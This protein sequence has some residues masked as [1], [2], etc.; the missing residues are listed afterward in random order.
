MTFLRE[1]DIIR[2]YTTNN[3]NKKRNSNRTWSHG[4]L[5]E[6]MTGPNLLFG[7]GNTI[8]KNSTTFMV[9]LRVQRG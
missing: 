7:R 3:N 2:K 9:V 8:D 1:H 6:T 4:I 5:K